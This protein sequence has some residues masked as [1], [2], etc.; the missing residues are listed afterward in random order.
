[1]IS[2]GE[3]TRYNGP[4]SWLLACISMLALNVQETWKIKINASI[5]TNISLL[6]LKSGVKI[7]LKINEYILK[8]KSFHILINRFIY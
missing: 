4:Y 8:I 1:M 3:V 7:N 2:E 6:N 5:Q